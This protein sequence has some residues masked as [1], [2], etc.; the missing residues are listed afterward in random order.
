[1]T[2]LR[3]RFSK[4]GAFLKKPEANQESSTIFSVWRDANVGDSSEKM[5]HPCTT[6]EAST[7][8][9]LCYFTKTQATALVSFT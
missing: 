5:F 6:P 4:T 9:H 1:M 7:V 8:E 3:V 2:P